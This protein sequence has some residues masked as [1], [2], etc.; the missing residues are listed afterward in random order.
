[1]SIK[2][3]VDKIVGE[4]SR[5][6]GL[7]DSDWAT[8]AAVKETTIAWSQDMGAVYH[9]ALY[10]DEEA[11]EA[12]RS[13]DSSDQKQAFAVWFERLASGSPGD[14]FWAETCLT[15]FAHAS[16]NIDNGNVIA[17]YGRVNDAL[18]RR[19]MEAFDPTRA[20]AV[21]GAFR[22]VFDVTVAV[23]VDSY[24]HALVTGMSQIGLNERLLKRMRVVAIRKMIDSGRDSIPLMTWDDALSVGIEAID[25]QHKKLIVI[26]NRLHESKGSGKGDATMKQILKELIDYTVYHFAFEEK[27]FDQHGY[28]ETLGHKESHRKLE[29]QVLEF[30]QAFEAG[31]ASLSA[32]L[33]MFLRGWLNG[34]IR[35]SDRQYSPFLACKVA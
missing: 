10:S 28:P 4:A 23:L 1:M 9:D 27:L 33:F 8:L 17:A 3:F 32:E 21:Y 25:D 22:R 14:T 11:A 19:V 34:H 29:A 5:R 35:G 24:V 16:A 7:A 2:E 30:A 26:L 20:I 15:G 6:T 12:M 31:S 13:V 18:L